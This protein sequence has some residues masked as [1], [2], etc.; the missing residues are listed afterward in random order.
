VTPESLSVSLHA[1]SRDGATVLAV[2]ES[3]SHPPE[4]FRIDRAT[5]ALTQLTHESAVLPP[6]LLGSVVELSWRSGDGRFTV[7]GFLV[8]PVDYAPDRCYPL[9]VIAHGGPGALFMNTFVGINFRPASIPPQLLAAAGYLVL[10]PNPRGDPSYGVTYQAALSRAWGTGPFTDIDAGVSMLVERGIADSSAMGIVGASYGG[11]LTAFAIAHSHRFAAASINDAPV[12][13]VS[14]YGQNYATHSPWSAYFG[15]T[16]WKERALYVS[17]SPITHI[18]EVRTPVLMRYGGRSATHD[19]IRQAYMLA[20][21]FELYAALHDIGVPVRFLL[22]PDQG[23]GVTDWNLYQEWIGENLKW[24][25]F[26]LRHEGSNPV[27][28]RE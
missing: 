20:Q 7:H 4:L 10:L 15:G 22:H 25:G 26:W 12:D 1:V 8:K 14:E 17:Q 9:I 11:Y 21:G 5:G 6:M 28:S 2:L 24:F 13:L 3:G 27:A 18:E 19:N 16:P 23:H